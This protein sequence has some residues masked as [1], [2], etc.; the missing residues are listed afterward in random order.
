M[1]SLCE[2]DCIGTGV[3]YNTRM[4]KR[5]SRIQ[6]VRVLVQAMVLGIMT[7]AGFNTKHISDWLFPTVLLVGVFFCGWVCPLGAA[8]DWVAALG[9]WLRLPRLRVPAGLQRYM[10]LLRYVFYALLLMEISISLLKGP[11]HFSRLV[12]GELLTAASGV[13]VLFLLLGL[14]MD[15]PFCNYFCTGGARQGLFSVLRIFGIR[16][17]TERCGGCGRC[18][19]RCPMNIDVA[20]TDFVRHPNCIGCMTCLSTCPKKCISYGLFRSARK[21]ES[22]R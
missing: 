8:Q 14:F 17:D 1:T 22:G 20:A 13:I 7:F 9:R 5:F 19:A 2:R 21:S 4:K 16:R 12:H 15:R 10:Q 3:W 6:I 18:S 11:Y